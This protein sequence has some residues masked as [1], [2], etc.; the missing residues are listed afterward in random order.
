M[1]KTG[2]GEKRPKL[3][4]EAGR[5]DLGLPRVHLPTSV[6]LVVARVCNEGGWA[7]DMATTTPRHPPGATAL[8]SHIHPWIFSPLW[9]PCGFPR[10]PPQNPI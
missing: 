1:R 10:V 9:P 4:G 8:I 2:R 7:I 6:S 5:S 3:W